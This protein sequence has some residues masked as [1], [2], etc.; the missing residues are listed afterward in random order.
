MSMNQFSLFSSTRFYSLLGAGLLVIFAS[1]NVYCQRLLYFPFDETSGTETTAEIIGQTSFLI[2]NNFNSPERIE[3]ASGAALRFDGWSTWI[4][5][6]NFNIEGVTRSMSIECWYATESFTAA[7]SAIVSQENSTSGFTVEIE[8]F[9]KVVF[10]FWVDEVRYVLVTDQMLEKYRWNHIVTTID[11]DNKRAR[12][13]VNGQIWKETVLTNHTAIALSTSRFYL[14]R[15][16][17]WQQTSGF[18]LTILNGALDEFSVYKN[19]LELTDVQGNYINFKDKPVNLTIDPAVRHKDDHLRPRYHAMPNTS[20]TNESYGL[21]YYNDRY[22][23]FFQKNPNGPYLYFMHWG[24]LSS[25]DLVAWKEENISLSPSTGFDNFGVWSGTTIPDENGKPVILY[26]GVNGAKAAIGL[27]TS[28]DEELHDWVKYELNPVIQE[29]PADVKHMDFRDPF[30]W[31]YNN[32]YYMIIGS[33]I[34]NGAGG[35]LFTYKSTDLKSWSRTTTLY[36]DVNTARS[37]YFWEMPFFHQLNEKDW[38]LCVTPTPSN[39]VPAKSI[40]WIGSFSGA[41]FTPYDLTPRSFELISDNLLS[42]S[43]GTDEAGR[44]TYLAII[45]EARNVDAQVKAGWRHLFSLPRQLRLLNDS[46]IGHIPHPNLC[47]LRDTHVNI[48]QRVI[49]AGNKFNLPEVF[50][51]Q[52]ELDFNIK[53]DS[54]A[55]FSIRIF[56]HEDEAE[57]TSV[58]FDLSKNQILLDRTKSTFSDAAKDVRQASYFF[59]HNEPINVRMFLDHSVLEIYIDQTVVFSCRVYPSRAASDKVDLVVTDKTVKLINL[60]A[61]RMKNLVSPLTVSVCE[62][63]PASLPTALRKPITQVIT[64]VSIEKIDVNVY[65]NPAADKVIIQYNSGQPFMEGTISLYDEAGKAI[66]THV[67]TFLEN[68]YVLENLS[69]GLYYVVVEIGG[70]KRT[71]KVIFGV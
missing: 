11:L 52:L 24:H 13:F 49:S 20:W 36:N 69:E 51:T 54:A 25:T 1:L 8:P 41:K 58:H 45:P 57:F 17:D 4:E 18:G 43:I 14:G 3:G 40:Y 59:D 42:P 2:K 30:V 21:T 61:W 35:Y 15:D 53:A 39:G 65:P 62:P 48:T 32:S 63:D 22:H 60:E 55:K 33:G 28:P 34:Q 19:S 9:G 47:R 38:I 64:G 6:D 12:I 29:A 68:K 66:S 5:K 56:L 50:G 7:N 23:L 44:L 26:T 10:I 67:I 31:K 46:S 37:G 16:T 71:F 70:K 27:A